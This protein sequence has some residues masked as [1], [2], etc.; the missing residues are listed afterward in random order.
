MT[1]Q[2]NINAILAAKTPQ[3]AAML[4][5]TAIESD[6]TNAVTLLNG[7]KEKAAGNP[8]LLIE[9]GKLFWKLDLRGEAMSAYEAAAIE[10]P[11]GPA[12]LLIEHS[13]SIMDFF[14][15]DLLNP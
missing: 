5:K 14:N 8:A 4:L 3:E 15:T 10:D 1:E 9:I 11:D 6:R 7:L 2:Q 12:H 13:N